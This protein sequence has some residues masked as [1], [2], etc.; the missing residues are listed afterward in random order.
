MTRR[1]SIDKTEFE[2]HFAAEAGQFRHSLREGVDRLGFRD[3]PM[4]GH[5]VTFSPND[6][7]GKVSCPLTGMHI[8]WDGFDRKEFMERRKQFDRLLDE[9]LEHTVGYAH[10][11]VIRPEW[12]LEIDLQPFNPAIRWPFEPFES[13][14]NPHPKRWDI[15]ISARLDELDPRLEHILFVEARMYFID[16][17]KKTGKTHR[18]FTIQG[19]NSPKKGIE[20]FN[21]M[22]DYLF[23]AGGMMGAIK[24]E[25]TCHWRAVGNPRI[26]PPT[27]RKVVTV[28]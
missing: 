23:T 11:E 10:C 7:L 6:P 9:E 17:L 21:Q 8:T 15:H 27:I 3:D 12:D 20:V 14:H 16:L 26:A 22:A 4:I 13:T 1:S 2:I 5:G 25:D 28:A 18:I 19:S 24:F